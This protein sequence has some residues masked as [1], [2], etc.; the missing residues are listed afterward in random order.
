MAGMWW[1]WWKHSEQTDPLCCTRFVLLVHLQMVSSCSPHTTP[2]AVQA[3][4]SHWLADVNLIPRSPFNL[5]AGWRGYM[6]CVSHSE[7]GCV[8]VQRWRAT[9]SSVCGVWPHCRKRGSP[10]RRLV[11]CCVPRRLTLSSA[12]MDELCFHLWWGRNEQ[13][14]EMILFGWLRCS[15]T[16]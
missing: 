14:W 1:E 16:N 8:V 9:R 10:R 2:S 3:H 6:V 5:T 4:M 15:E 13:R 7:C 12:S 11:G